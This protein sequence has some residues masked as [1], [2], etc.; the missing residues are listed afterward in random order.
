MLVQE[1]IIVEA[2]GEK[3]AQLGCV[4]AH[5]RV[6]VQGEAEDFKVHAANSDLNDHGAHSSSGTHEACLIIVI[7]ADFFF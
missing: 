4:P 5:G 3:A 2:G 7:V 6:R 1:G